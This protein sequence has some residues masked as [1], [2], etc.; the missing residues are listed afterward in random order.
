MNNAC[1]FNPHECNSANALGRCI[2][3]DLSKVD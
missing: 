2:E 1:G 3:I